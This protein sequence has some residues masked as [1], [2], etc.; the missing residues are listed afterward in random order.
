M[1]SPLNAELT[2]MQR[3]GIGVGQCGKFSHTPE[4]LG[5]RLAV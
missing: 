3:M 5:W 2:T 4:P 1:V